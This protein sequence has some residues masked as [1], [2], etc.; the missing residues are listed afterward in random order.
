[1]KKAAGADFFGAY[2]TQAAYAEC[3]LHQEAIHGGRI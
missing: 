1:M 2:C 3:T